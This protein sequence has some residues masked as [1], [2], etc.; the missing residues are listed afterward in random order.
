MRPNP[1]PLIALC[2]LSFA[3]F[4]LPARAAGLDL[5]VWT[6]GSRVQA[7]CYRGDVLEVR[8][9]PAAARAVSPRGAR[10]T[11]AVAVGR[12]GVPAI[13]ALSAS[14]GIV[15]FEPEFRG[16]TPPADAREPDFTAFRLLHLAPGSDLAEALDR[17]RA[18]PDVASADPIALLPVSA[19]LP[20]DSLAFA[21]FWLY[22]NQ[23]VRTDIRAPE[24]W[25]V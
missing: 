21:T 8:L 14:L 7:P 18:L 10:P 17:L 13:D 15:A 2:A 6:P 24:A 5:P 16:E 11:R 25:Q 1:I 19:A 4:A 20:N 22:K 3:S 9:T 23:P 12:L